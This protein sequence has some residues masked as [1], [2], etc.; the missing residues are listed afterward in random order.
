MC[1]CVCV[2]K[3]ASSLKNQVLF[4]RLF[5]KKKVE[6]VKILL[7]KSSDRGSKQQ[8]NNKKKEKIYL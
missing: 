7:F 5:N 6:Q 3:M 8:T 4:T 2:S 1:R